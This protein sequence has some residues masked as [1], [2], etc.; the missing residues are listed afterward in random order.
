MGNLFLQESRGGSSVLAGHDLFGPHREMKTI[1]QYLQDL[2]STASAIQV[3]I[4]ILRSVKGSSNRSVID[5]NTNLERV[6]SV[7]GEQ[8]N[9]L[10]HAIISF[11]SHTGTQL[12]NKLVAQ[13]VTQTGRT[14]PAS[15]GL[16]NRT[17]PGPS[18]PRTA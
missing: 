5:L 10:Q 3:V 9:Y 13:I 17:G 11:H 18:L 7:M 12:V 15:T 8:I 4:K 16:T 1:L 2:D 6:E 14:E